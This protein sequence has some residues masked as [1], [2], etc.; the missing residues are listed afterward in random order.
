MEEKIKNLNQLLCDL[1]IFAVKLQN[2][3]WNVRGKDFFVL[4]SKLEEYYDEVNKQIDEIAEH[5]LMLGE[6]P[7]GTMQDYLNNT[8]IVEA[9][10]E[11]IEEKAIFENIINDLGTLLNKVTNIKEESDKQNMYATSSLMDE[12][13]EGYMKKLWM[14]RQR[15][16]GDRS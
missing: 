9:K 3:H 4:H 11:K 5:I 6:Q 8:C 14:C 7:L 1:E 13:I 10:N 2:Y 15:D 12:Y 16:K